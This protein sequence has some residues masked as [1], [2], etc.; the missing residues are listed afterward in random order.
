MGQKVN[1]VGFRLSI[2][3]KWQSTWFDTKNFAKNLLRDI[4]IRKHIKTAY[5]KSGI[6]EVNIERTG[7]RVTVI[8]KTSKPGVLIGKKGADIEKIKKTIEKMGEKE[9]AIKVVEVDKPN[10]D[11]EIVAQ[12]IAKQIENRGSYRR[13]IKKA[14]QSAMRYGIRG[15]KISAAGRLNGAEIART[16]MYK[17]G[18][19][20]LHTLKANINYATAEAHTTYG[21]VGIKVWIYKQ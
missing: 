20:S 3:H 16:E 7:N 9:V 17:E 19:V 18:A 6:S 13:A 2:N 4:K 15:I 5:A 1:P 10:I 14:I 12:A 21:V 11:A 8:I